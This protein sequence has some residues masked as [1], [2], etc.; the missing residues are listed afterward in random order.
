M[1]NEEACILETLLPLQA[2]RQQ[3][4]EVILVDGGSQD[5]T[6]AKAQ[7]YVDRLLV[8]KPGRAR[9]MNTGAQAASGEVLLFLHADTILPERSIELVQERL[10][11][12]Y[13]WGRFD[14]RLSG[15]AWLLRV[16]E[17][18]INLRSRLTGIA[19]GDQAIFVLA[20]RFVAMGGYEEI[21]LMEDVAFSR[22]MR[23]QRLAPACLSTTLLTSS[24]RWEQQGILRTIVLMWM[25]RWRYFMGTEAKRLVRHYYK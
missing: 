3:G 19:T 9:Q 11:Q 8:S 7:P 2:Y 6:C 18:M 4:H 14:L 16:V 13:Q 12:G 25:L 24:R 10:A 1:L 22:T 23:R 5:L 20:T 17:K 15:R 21:P